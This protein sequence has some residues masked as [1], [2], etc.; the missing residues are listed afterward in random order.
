MKK[1][2]KS[3]T[4]ESDVGAVKIGNE[5]FTF[6]L[7][8]G[9]GDVRNVIEIW[10]VAG[11]YEETKFDEEF[12]FMINGEEINIYQYDC[13]KPVKEN[14]AYTIHGEH[15]VYIDYKHDFGNTGRI[16]FVK[17]IDR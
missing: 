4:T 10:E 17:H 5:S 12:E 2:V 14:V 8:N 9:I 16:L 11:N 7:P 6:N 3:F 1:L 13:D 15:A